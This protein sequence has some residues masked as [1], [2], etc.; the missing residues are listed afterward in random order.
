[1]QYGL[2]VY[3]AP[4]ALAARQDPARADAY[5]AAYQ[6]YSQALTEAGVNAGGAALQGVEVATTVRLV[7]G[8]RQVQDGPFADTKE[9]LGGIFVIDVPDLDA[10]LAWAARC[11]AANGGSV[12]VRPLLSMPAALGT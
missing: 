9:L 10:A 12:E 5:W 7:D 1:M 2:I 8:V 6:A 4:S 3:E 11:P